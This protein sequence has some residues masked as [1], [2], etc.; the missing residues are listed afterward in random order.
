MSSLQQHDIPMDIA[1]CHDYQRHAQQI[2][3]APSWQD[4]SEIIKLTKLP[5]YLKGILSV[6]DALKAQ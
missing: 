5:V 4:I 1:C 6:S 2:L 3:P